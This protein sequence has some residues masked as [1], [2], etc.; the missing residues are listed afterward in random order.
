M[1]VTIPGEWAERWMRQMN[2]P[3]AELR[4]DEQDSDRKEARRM[5]AIVAAARSALP[6]PLDVSTTVSEIRD[7]EANDGALLSTDLFIEGRGMSVLVNATIHGEVTFTVSVDGVRRKSG[8]LRSALPPPLEG[9][10]VIEPQMSRVC[11]RGSVGCMVRHRAA[12]P[13]VPE[14]ASPDDVM[15]IYVPGA[16][17]CPT[18]GFALSQATLFMGSG[19]IGC[20]RDQVMKMAGELCP[21]DGAAMHRVTWRDRAVEN[22]AWGESLMN[23]II[24]AVGAE[25]LPGALDR[26]RE[27]RAARAGAEAPPV[28]VK[29]CTCPIERW[30]ARYGDHE[31]TCPS[32]V[33]AGAEAPPPEEP[34]DDEAPRVPGVPA[35]DQG[36][37]PRSSDQLAPS[38]AE[39]TEP[40]CYDC[41][42]PIVGRVVWLAEDYR[43]E[44]GE[45]EGPHAFHPA[46]AEKPWPLYE[47]T[48]YRAAQLEAEKRAVRPAT[49]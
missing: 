6:L 17:K 33:A 41:K 48:P 42:R 37:L 38:A 18:C 29:P 26:I 8:T 5:L 21:N 13:R 24:E 46:C 31:S 4:Y 25:H 1:A 20:S 35:A 19:E 12:L 49:E 10:C 43:Q 2:T 22:Q 30:S 44:G 11:E 7:G 47:V 27:L 16:W 45:I 3:Y 32:F 14:P 9:A 28:D 40:T 15:D 36:D 39:R 34:K 23:E